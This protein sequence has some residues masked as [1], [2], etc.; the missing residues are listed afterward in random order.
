MSGGIVMKIYV[1]TS[2]RNED[3]PWIV[4]RLK[5]KGHQVYDFRN[6]TPDNHGFAWG[7]ID[8]NWKDWTPEQFIE[9]LKHPIAEEGFAFD[10][11]ALDW[12]EALVLVMPCGR[13]AHLEA[14][15]AAG[16]GKPV[17]VLLSDAEPE[18]M[19]KLATGGI[20]HRFEEMPL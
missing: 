4:E 17:Y 13:S 9:A 19:Y 10:K 5:E 15:Y 6:P 20:Y 8:L 1:A 12:A 14:G 11:N 7:A 2:W 3:Q 18:L 16:Q